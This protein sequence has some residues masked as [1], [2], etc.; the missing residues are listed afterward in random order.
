MAG[1]G[2]DVHE[3]AVGAE[4]GEEGEGGEEG[5]VVVCLEGLFYDIDVWMGYVL[6]WV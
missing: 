3:A 1:C 2:G 6:V 5:A 4:E